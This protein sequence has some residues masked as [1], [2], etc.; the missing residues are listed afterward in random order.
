MLNKEKYFGFIAARSGSKGIKN[1]NLRK[2][3]NISLFEYSAT[4]LISARYINQ[5]FCATDDEKIKKI[6]KKIN[7]DFDYERPEKLSDDSST[8]I[9]LLYDF[10][11]EKNL[12]DK[13]KYVVLVQA[14]TPTVTSEIIDSCINKFDKSDA[15]SLITGYRFSNVN[16]AILYKTDADDNVQ[17][18]DN[19]FNKL[20]QNF[21]NNYFVRVG[22]VYIFSLKYI[23]NKDLYGKKI[24]NFEIPKN[25]SINIDNLNDLYHARKIMKKGFSFGK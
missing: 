12:Y 11:K 15:D 16:P 24:I 7:I 6:C 10:I 4:A 20:R 25:I 21:D 17:Y 8:I 18:L 9:S 5:S 1:K 19:N 14:T 22:M 3:N 23:I 2:I 13:Y